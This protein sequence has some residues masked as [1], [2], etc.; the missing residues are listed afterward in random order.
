MTVFGE[1]GRA[2]LPAPIPV[3][4]P[5]AQATRQEQGRWRQRQWAVELRAMKLR[6]RKPNPAVMSVPVRLYCNNT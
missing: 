5:M 2:G 1:T 4:P 6:Q 3:V